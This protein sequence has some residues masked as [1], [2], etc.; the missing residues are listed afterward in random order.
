MK[1]DLHPKLQN[2]QGLVAKNRSVDV[3]RTGV[4]QELMLYILGFCW[5]QDEHHSLESEGVKYKSWVEDFPHL[6]MMDGD[7]RCLL[8]LQ[9]LKPP[10]MDLQIWRDQHSNVQ[11]AFHFHALWQNPLDRLDV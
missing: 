3:E 5:L 6:M 8:L 1:M 9:L 4:D 10:L 7:L 2:Q 11:F